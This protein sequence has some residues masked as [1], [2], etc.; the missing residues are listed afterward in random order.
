[1]YYPLAEVSSEDLG[2]TKGNLA[3]LTPRVPDERYDTCSATMLLFSA[4]A[5]LGKWSM[6]WGLRQV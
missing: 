2:L 5:G 4:E 1:V 3:P 6:L